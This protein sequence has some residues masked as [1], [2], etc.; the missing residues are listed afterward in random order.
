M[1]ILSPGI[2][3]DNPNF[4]LAM[5]SQG[6]NSQGYTGMNNQGYPF[7]DSAVNGYTPQGSMATPVRP[8]GHLHDLLSSRPQGGGALPRAV[9]GFG[10]A[11]SG[12][13]PMPI[14]S[15]RPSIGSAFARPPGGGGQLPH[16]TP[17]GWTL[18][19]TLMLRW[20]HGLRIIT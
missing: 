5:W 13:Q 8:G 7:M 11:A 6:G 1:D 15:G 17:L 3:G 20:I 14:G 2:S 19:M 16:W 10:G 12:I 9:Q 18:D 4:G